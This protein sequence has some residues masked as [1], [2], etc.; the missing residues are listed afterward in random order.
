VSG[1]LTGFAIIGL[2]IAVGYFCARF[3][4]D[5]PDKV[6]Q[7][8]LNRI[9]FLVAMPALIFT[10]VA[11]TPIGL[12]LGP[13]LLIQLVVVAL[14]I[15][16]F[17]LVMKISNT[18]GLQKTDYIVGATATG[19]VNANNM[20]LPIAI[21][22]LGNPTAVVPVVL[23]QL[24][25]FAPIVLLLLDASTAARVSWKLILLQPIRNPVILASVAGALVSG[26]NWQVPPYIWEPLRSLGGAAIPMMLMAFGMSL[27]GAKPLQAGLAPRR[28]IVVAS[29]IKS[30]LMPVTAFIV[31]R[32]VFQLDQQGTLTAVVIASLPT[33]QNVYNYS[34]RYSASEILARDA[35]LLTTLLTPVTLIWAAALLA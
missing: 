1:I 21:F 34:A 24:L 10:V 22:V 31:A 12:M 18:Q 26:F 35:V 33:A 17:L 11:D 32:L 7:K 2:L 29:L 4:I 8:A 20:G 14:M 27:V 30:I 9:S 25:V 28:A 5:G 16:V 13:Q 23:L 3:G 15:A 6:T 19:Y